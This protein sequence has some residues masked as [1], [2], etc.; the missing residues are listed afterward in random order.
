MSDRTVAQQILDAPEEDDTVQVEEAALQPFVE[1]QPVL[2]DGWIVLP[3][4]NLWA[5]AES[6]IDSGYGK[7][8]SG[9][10]S[11]MADLGYVLFVAVLYIGEFIASD[12]S[13]PEGS[14]SWEQYETLLTKFATLQAKMQLQYQKS[15]TAE[16]N[17]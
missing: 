16:A 14:I 5:G 1:M 12:V 8:N 11:K 4:T 3:V 17:F 13:I 6:Q 7:L 15:L 9:T 10:S 2:Q